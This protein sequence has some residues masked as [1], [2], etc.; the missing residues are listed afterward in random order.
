MSWRRAGRT[1]LLGLALVG[2][3]VVVGCGGSAENHV[4]ENLT[5]EAQWNDSPSAVDQIGY[6]LVVDLVWSDRLQSCFLLSPNLGIHIDDDVVV[7][8]PIEGDCAYESLVIVGGIKTEGSTTVTLQDGDQVLGE[9]IFDGLFPDTGA[10]VT[11]PA[12]GQ[13][14]K[15]GD[16]IAVALPKPAQPDLVAARFYWTDT[17]STVPPF[18]SFVSGTVSADGL[19]FQGTAPTITSGRALVVVESSF[20]EGNF[21]AATSCTGFQFCNGLPSFEMAGPVSIDV[22]P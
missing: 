3:M 4:P 8:P 19:T 15:A 10:T 14:V 6:Q 5:V 21:V 12:A 16:P 18:Y 7:A 11:T 2:G 22:V 1:G 20:G 13:P 9:A 17:P